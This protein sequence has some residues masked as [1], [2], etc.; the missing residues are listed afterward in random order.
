MSRCWKI[1]LKQELEDRQWLSGYGQIR[2]T[3]AEGGSLKYRTLRAEAF[4]ELGP[5]M[6]R[7]EQSELAGRKE[8]ACLLETLK[9]T[10]F[11]FKG[12]RGLLPKRGLISS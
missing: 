1:Q 12:C 11:D 7:W 9:E 6:I 8:R 3:V 2:L 10:Y 5:M 4:T